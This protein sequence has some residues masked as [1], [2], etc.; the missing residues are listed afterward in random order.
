VPAGTLVEFEA[1]DRIMNMMIITRPLELLHHLQRTSYRGED[2]MGGLRPSALIQWSYASVRTD[3]LFFLF[4][5]QDGHRGAF[6]ICSIFCGHI[7]T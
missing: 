2:G 4:L 7:S 5:Q 3:P 6:R 1:P